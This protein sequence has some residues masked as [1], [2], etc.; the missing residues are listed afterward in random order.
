MKE[1]NEILPPPSPTFGPEWERLYVKFEIKGIEFSMMKI[2]KGDG[3]NISNKNSEDD[4]DEDFDEEQDTKLES[5]L[6]MSLIN[7]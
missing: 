2:F 1:S 3:S 7:L 4:D 5:N 6:I